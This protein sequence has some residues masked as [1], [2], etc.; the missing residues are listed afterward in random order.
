M[1]AVVQRVSFGQVTVDEE[2]VGKIEAGVVV[3]IGAEKGDLTKDAFYIADKITHL[4]I[5]EDDDGKM[6]RSLLDTGGEALVVSQFT[7]L[8]DARKGRRPAFIKAEAPEQAEQRCE[9]VI[10]RLKDNGIK[11]VESGRFRT[12]MKVRL[13]NNGPIT[14]LL[15]SKKT[16]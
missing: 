9:E 3:L 8:G 6:N 1:R 16:F 2:I 13:E 10:S 5:F 14:I 12:D 4:R 7:L 11:N 15:D